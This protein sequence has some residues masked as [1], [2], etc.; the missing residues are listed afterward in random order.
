MPPSPGGVATAAIVSVK[1]T[2]H[3]PDPMLKAFS[4]GSRFPCRIFQKA[5][6]QPG[7][8]SLQI[9]TVVV[10]ALEG[11]E[12]RVARKLLHAPHIAPACVERKCD[13]RMAQTVRA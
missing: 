13:G 1:S 4:D 5:G 7:D 11:F 3:F 9:V 10:V 2:V 8:I 6:Q 12:A